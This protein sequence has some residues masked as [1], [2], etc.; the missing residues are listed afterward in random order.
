MTNKHEEE[1]EVEVIE[2][3]T[4]APVLQDICYPVSENSLRL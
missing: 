3:E 4:K 2:D 1:I